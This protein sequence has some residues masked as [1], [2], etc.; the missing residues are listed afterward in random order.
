MYYYIYDSF[1]REEKYAKEISK[2]SLKLTDLDILGEEAKVTPIRKIKDL[3]NEALSRGYKNIVAVG[4]D[5]TICSVTQC[6][7]SQNWD[8]CLGMIPLKD[9]TVAQA[10]GIPQGDQACEIISARRIEK[11]DLGKINNRFFLTSVKIGPS[12]FV[13][14]ALKFRNLRSI[15]QEKYPEIKLKFNEGFSVTGKISMLSILNILGTK[16]GKLEMSTQ[17]QNIKL[18]VSP[19]DS[20]LDIVMIGPQSKFGLL[21]NISSIVKQ[22][23]ESIPNL[24]FF[25]TKRLEISTENELTCLI[26]GQP[27]KTLPFVVE[28]VP[29]A[30]NIIVGKERQF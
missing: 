18:K 16:Q 23:F 24:S 10:L 20:L 1:T 4:N 12:K 14:S 13:Q 9:S 21:K 6:L 7:V 15:F 22:S 2:V 28:I 25:R 26:D 3:V 19:K 8:G 30:L 17:K 29:K 5:S 27:V 11:I